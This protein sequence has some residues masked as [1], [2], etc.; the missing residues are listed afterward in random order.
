M[1][2]E[3]E[4][5][6][7][8]LIDKIGMIFI[9]LIVI[10]LNI[11]IG[12]NIKDPIWIIQMISAIFTLIY[13]ILKKI[14]KE[15]NIVIKGK[16]DIAVLVFMISTTIPLLFKTYASLNGTV[17][18]ILKYWSVYG[19]YILVRNIVNNKKRV[20]LLINTFLISS[21]I[22]IIF[23]YDKLLNL[24][25]FHSLYDLIN[26]VKI[27]DYR[28]ISTF[29]YA[30]TFAAYLGVMLSLA[31]AM[32]LNS[33]KKR[34]K[35]IYGIYILISSITIVLTQSKFVI[36][37]LGLIAFIFV[38]IG[39]KKKVITRKYIILGISCII[40]FFIYFFIGINISKPL[41]I[42]EEEKNCVIRGIDSNTEYELKF[43]IDSFS[44]NQNNIFEIRIVEI[45]RYLTSET[46]ETISFGNL[47]SEDLK[48]NITT[49]EEIDHLEIIFTNKY[50]QHLTINDFYINGEKYILEY[51]IIPDEL[52]RMF[53][54]FNFKNSSVWQ[55]ADYW[56]DG[57]DIIKENWLFGAGGNAWRMLY[58]SIQDYLYYAKEA[59]C[60]IL[61]IWMSF[62][63]VGILA[64]I[65]IIAITIKN[66]IANLKER[67]KS[68]EKKTYIS[69]VLG[70]IIILLHSLMDFDMSFLIMEFL[71]FILLSL[72]NKDDNMID[73]KWTKIPDVVI[74]I[75]FIIISGF[76]LLGLTAD[77]LNED[78]PILS[79]KIAPWI[80]KYKY[81]IIVYNANYKIQNEDQL[82]RTISFI[83]EEPYQ[84]QNTVNE[85]LVDNLIKQID[86]K[87]Y[88]TNKENIEFLIDYWNNTKI[89]RP[90]EIGTVRDRMGFMNEL[91]TKLNDEYLKNKDEDIKQKMLEIIDLAEK[92]KEKDKII[93]DY[94]KSGEGKGISKL[95]YESFNN[96][97]I[98]ILK[99]KEQIN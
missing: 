32:F 22:P 78:N 44:E 86:E 96:S 89:E 11:F 84:Y 39:I 38:L 19:I 15:K 50:G 43:N 66:I 35:A 54:T 49:G 42:V 45:T 1:K 13:I 83:D 59:H 73:N 72:I 33:D 41:E 3:K 21:I 36:A 40:I 75:I 90:Y 24:N 34:F 94:R 9:I 27:D 60:Y 77:L 70:F 65:C 80:S 67:K 74:A 47:T 20:N 7:R 6:N 46:L 81:N 25:I 18:F 88:D 53:T 52:V 95:I 82:D 16:I 28:M 91:L 55:R 85:I 99:I 61:E 97:Y 69:I 93:L 12:S 8:D 14:K 30:N 62:G 56:M 4:L 10:L 92:I 29:G 58:G 51:K 64:F 76:N 2:V 57:L 31:I 71:F 87:G 68:K 37:L 5:K 23:G 98:E 17:N 48:V 79:N 63:L 26:S